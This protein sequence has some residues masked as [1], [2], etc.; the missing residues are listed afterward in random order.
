MVAV[1]D[2]FNLSQ[3][4]VS[5]YIGLSKLTH[6]STGM[7]RFFTDSFELKCTTTEM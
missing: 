1:G 6:A 7:G 4:F 5:V 3:L 2:H